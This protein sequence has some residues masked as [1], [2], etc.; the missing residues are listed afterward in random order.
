MPTSKFFQQCPPFP[1]DTPVLN[2]PAVS[3]KQLQDGNAE[4]AERLYTAC[5]AWGFLLLDLRESADGQTLLEDAEKMY[6]LTKET[7]NLDQSVLDEHAYKP[8][9][10]LTGYVKPYPLKNQ[11]S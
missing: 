7:F 4:E 9:Y 11:P 6:D 8:P 1:A 2:L 5:R 3:L 10:D